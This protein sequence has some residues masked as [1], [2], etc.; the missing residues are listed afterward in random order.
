M[1][2]DPYWMPELNSNLSSAE[3]QDYP[4]H[5]LVQHFIFTVCRLGQ[6]SIKY[7]GDEQQKFQLS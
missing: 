7:V 1:L 5:L 2:D 4:Q 3:V 6:V